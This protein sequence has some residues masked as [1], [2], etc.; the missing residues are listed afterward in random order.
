MK[1]K[2]LLSYNGANFE[3]SQVQS[4]TSNTIMGQIYK[5]FERLGIK[6]K[7]HASGRT[8]AGVHAFKQVMHCEIPTFWSDIKKLQDHLNFQLPDSIKLRQLSFVNEDFHARYSAKRRAYRYI[9]SSSES[10]PF[11]SAFISFIKHELNLNLLKD[12]MVVFEG[13]HDFSSFMKSGSTTGSNI[14]HIYKTRVYTYQGR[15]VLYFE[16]NG[17][18][19]SQIR[20]M[21]AF[22]LKIAQEKLTKEQL[23]EQLNNQE[24]Y[25]TKP[26]P[27]N[28]HYLS[29]IIY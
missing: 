29:N 25:N 28:G 26:A 2:L 13:E 24:K 19:R 12:A 6:T 23:L 14:R 18:L 10:N 17:F 4:H 9:L 20:L 11:E 5:A 27:P 21:V 15:T 8:D 16:A 7:L 3:G 22:L 1:I